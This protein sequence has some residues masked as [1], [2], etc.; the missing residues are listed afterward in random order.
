M[1]KTPHPKKNQT[2]RKNTFNDPIKRQPAFDISSSN[3]EPTHS[4]R[5]SKIYA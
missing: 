2:K 1:I 4:H 5:Y 3:E